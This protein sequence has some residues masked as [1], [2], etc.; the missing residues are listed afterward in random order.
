MSIEEIVHEELN[1]GWNRI[2]GALLKRVRKR[3][4]LAYLSGEQL[5]EIEKAFKSWVKE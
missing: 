4:N 1:S 3:L 5:Q 2:I